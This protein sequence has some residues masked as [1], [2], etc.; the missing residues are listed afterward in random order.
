MRKDIPRS[1]S[2]VIL[3]DRLENKIEA[4]LGDN[5]LGDN[6]FRFRKSKGTRDTTRALRILSER[7]IEKSMKKSQTCCK[8]KQIFFWFKK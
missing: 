2:K 8:T 5:Q 3:N 7:L 4:R 6:Q 1:Y